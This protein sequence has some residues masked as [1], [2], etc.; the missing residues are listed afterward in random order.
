MNSFL[1]ILLHKLKQHE[2]FENFK[3]KN[4]N[5]DKSKWNTND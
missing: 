5:Y 3:Y 2:N 4:L 1:Q